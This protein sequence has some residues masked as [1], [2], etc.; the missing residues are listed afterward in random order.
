M[1]LYD[2]HGPVQEMPR[3]HGPEW[4]AMGGEVC[5]CTHH[6]DE[7]HQFNLGTPAYFAGSCM[8]DVCGCSRFRPLD[9]Q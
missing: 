2:E 1:S 6:V 3:E 4:W 9:N 5:Q 7:H 8:D